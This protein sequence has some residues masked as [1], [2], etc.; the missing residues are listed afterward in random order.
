MAGQWYL[1]ET[2]SCIPRWVPPTYPY[3]EQTEHDVQSVRLSLGLHEGHDA[4]LE[5]AEQ[6]AGQQRLTV[7]L[8]P[9]PDSGDTTRSG[10]VRRGQTGSDGV[11]RGQMRSDEVRCDRTGSDGAR[12]GHE[13]SDG[14]DE[15]DG[16]KS[17]LTGSDRVRSDGIRWNPMGSITVSEKWPISTLF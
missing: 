17:G 16:V 14:S 10:A 12:R 3:S 6:Q 13:E 11:R 15:G 9:R 7:P 2:V 4:L 1:W 8:P 5:G